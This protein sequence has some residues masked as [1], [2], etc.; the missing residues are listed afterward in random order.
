MNSIGRIF[1]IHI[2]GESHGEC[3]G[4]IIDGCPAGLPIAVT[5]FEKDLERRKGG[6]QKGTTPRKEDDI[7]LIKT[8]VFNGKTT[9][10]PITILF[11]NNNTRSGDYEKQKAIPRPGH[12]DFTAGV[13]YGGY[14]DYR[15]GGHFSGRL[16]VGLV[17]AGVIAK[18]LL[19][20]AIP[21]A[22][23]LEIGGEADIEKGLQKAIDQ[24]DSIG[25]IVECRVSGLPAG[26]GEHFFDSVESVLAHAVFSIPAIKGIEFGAGF[27]AARMFGS[28]HNDSILDATGK[29]GSNHAGGVV[30]GITNGNELVFRVA[31]KPTSSTPKEQTTWNRETEQLDTLSVKGRHDLCIALRV[32]VVLEA[33][34]AVVLTDLMLL[35][36]KINKI[37]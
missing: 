26:L 32:P 11:E 7:P 34:T 2:I 19:Q 8:G 35:E 29:T 10:T 37:L 22:N 12:A 3:V 15:G 28:D 20:A 36:Q 23:I 16:T 13:K 24:K 30:G 25:G 4:V 27:S 21:V 5:D 9:G 14:E 1:R 18:K 6:T 17:A 31:V 33:V